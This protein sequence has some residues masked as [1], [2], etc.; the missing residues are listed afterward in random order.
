MDAEAEGRIHYRYVYPHGY[1]YPDY[2]PGLRRDMKR[3]REQMH[4]QQRRMEEQVRLQE[5][6]NRFLR[7]QV[8]EQQR[9]TGLQA[10]FYRFDAG[11]DLCEDLFDLTS[12]EYAECRDIVVEK[13]PSCSGD[14]AIPGGKYRE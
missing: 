4:G 8:T 14:I 6:Q 13:N 10:C 2:Q 9:V 1:H 7:Q 12:P 11:L 5:E 3:L